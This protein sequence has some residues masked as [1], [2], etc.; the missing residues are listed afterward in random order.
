MVYIWEFD[1]DDLVVYGL[2]V[3]LFVVEYGFIGIVVLVFGI[4]G[5]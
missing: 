1:V 5:D 2:L 4:F 3:V